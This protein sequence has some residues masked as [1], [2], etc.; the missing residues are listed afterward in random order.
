MSGATTRSSDS[1]LEVRDLT[2]RHGKIDAV[3][4][5]SLTVAPGRVTG[6]LGPNSAGK[7]SALQAML[8]AGRGRVSGTVEL[9]GRRLDQLTT[10]QRM[11]A[12]LRL[13]PEG[14]QIFPTL[15]AEENL[16]VVAESLRID[17]P[18]ARE[19]ARELF[20]EVFVAM[21]TAV[22]GNLS[23]GQQQMVALARA[24]IGDPRVLLLDEPALGLAV[25]V[26]R[27]VAQVVRALADSGVAVLLADQSLHLWDD[28]IDHSLVLLRGCLEATIS[29]QAELMKL[30]GH[31]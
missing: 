19:R 23:G 15:T 11:Q 4:G 21:P 27:R 8:G 1:P 17:W 26:T 22:A 28:L 31:D 3:R 10:T 29:S 2:V 16:R 5:I 24:V 12:G 18:S 20:P 30:L 25:G 14:R 6:L 9:G 13:V 7:S